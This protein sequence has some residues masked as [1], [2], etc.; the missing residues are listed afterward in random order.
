MSNDISAL[1]HRIDELEVRIA[2]QDDAMETL[3]RT[4]SEQT[5]INLDLQRQVLAMREAWS[6]FAAR[7]EHNSAGSGEE[8]PPHY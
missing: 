5:L 6:K 7:A 2:F 3:Q 1:A 8:L 4:L